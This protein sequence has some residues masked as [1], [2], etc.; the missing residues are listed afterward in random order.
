MEKEDNKE[1]II[2]DGPKPSTNESIVTT[3]GM[4]DAEKDIEGSKDIAVKQPRVE[5]SSEVMPM[6]A[7][8]EDR[9]TSR[10]LA[11]EQAVTLVRKDFPKIKKP[12]KEEIAAKYTILPIDQWMKPNSIDIINAT[13]CSC[14]TIA[15]W[16]GAYMEYK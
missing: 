1:D 5:E 4:S 15:P 12:T 10:E 9:P 8:L 7:G 14:P 13:S 11:E 3:K 2:E 6:P 16:T